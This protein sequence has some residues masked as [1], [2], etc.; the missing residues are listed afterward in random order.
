MPGR[1]AVTLLF[2]AM[3]ALSVRAAAGAVV[4]QG[5]AQDVADR[6]VE[7][8]GGREV[9]ANARTLYVREKAYPSSQAAPVTAEI[10]RDLHVPAYRS[11]IAGEGLRRETHYS[12]AGGWTIRNGVRTVMTPEL[13]A[14][15][16]ADWKTEP[17]VIYHRLAR[18]DPGLRLAL[19]NDRRL[20]VYDRTSGELIS[21][22]VVD[23]AGMLVLWGNYYEGKVSE[24]V[25]G[26]LV[27]FGRFRMPKWGAAT[28]GS[29][30]FEYE[31]V[32]AT[33]DS[34]VVRQ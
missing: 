25:Y 22:F 15:E 12:E 6:L 28:D 14:A 17:Y 33:A 20:E 26:P 30:R 27:P 23:V 10:W 19:V 3:I 29:W 5:R 21:W 1:P 24:H 4:A 16:I 9:W 13:L 32:R 31:V 11:I 34:L 7:G 8:L 18:R 2:A